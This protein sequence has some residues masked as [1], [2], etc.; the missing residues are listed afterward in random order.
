MRVYKGSTE[1]DVITDISSIRQAIKLVAFS[2]ER[3]GKSGFTSIIGD[4][5]R[6]NRPVARHLSLFKLV[7][8]PLKPT[9][10]NVIGVKDV[11]SLSP[12]V[13]E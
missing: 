3:V 12:I 11:N 5:I 4:D 13:I 6:E 9:L 10:R 2:K 8:T 1:S 7:T